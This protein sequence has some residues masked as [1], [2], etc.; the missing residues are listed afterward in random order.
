MKIEILTVRDPDSSTAV[1]MY[2]DGV[3]ATRYEGV[4]VD[5]GAGHEIQDWL[6][7]MV[8][9]YLADYTPAFKAAALEAYSSY[10]SNQFIMGDAEDAV[11]TCHHS[12]GHYPGTIKFCHWEHPWDNLESAAAALVQHTESA[13]PE[14]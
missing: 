10:E 2:I 13:H 6:Q 3:E 7:S 8:D 4:D 5:P 11:I 9:I 1:S 12:T 14:K